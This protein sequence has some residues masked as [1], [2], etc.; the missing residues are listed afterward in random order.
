MDSLPES[1]KMK[2]KISVLITTSLYHAINDGAISVIPILFPLFKDIFNLNYTQVGFISGGGLLITLFAQLMIGRKADGKNSKTLLSTGIVMM[3]ASLLLLTQSVD[4]IS[5][6]FFILL[7]RLSASFFHPI[8]VGWISRT[9][10]KERLDWAMGIQSGFAD[11]G[12]FIALSTTLFISSLTSWQVPLYI[13]AVA[14]IVGVLIA[15]FISRNLDESITTVK[16][17]NKKQKTLEEINDAYLLLKNIKILIPA[18]AISGAAWGVTITYLPLFLQEKTTL[19]LSLI[20][21]L[22]AFLIGIGSIVSF[23]YGKIID[24]VGRK[25]VVIFSYL[26]IGIMDIAIAFTNSIYV[27]IFIL[28]LLGISIFL[29]YPAL[30]SFISEITQENVEG[31]NFGVIFTLQLGGGTI[32]LIIGGA[33]SDAIGVSI[34]FILLG[35]I[36]LLFSLILL[37]LYKKP[38]ITNISV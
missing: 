8:G 28:I 1:Y 5:L 30:F 4:F 3:G 34:P 18:F 37:V 33:L 14:A 22:V 32:L 38:F 24:Y 6:L 29:S 15:T 2:E 35:S 21:L 9:F 17:K 10:K 13:W 19:S 12:A 11:V 25:N 36:S 31:K 20:G 23:F 26:T 7:I 16:H 27:F